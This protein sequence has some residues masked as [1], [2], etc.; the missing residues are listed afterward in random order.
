MITRSHS[1]GVDADGITITYII[2]YV[3]TKQ[4]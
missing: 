1:N 4:C 2:R 3:C